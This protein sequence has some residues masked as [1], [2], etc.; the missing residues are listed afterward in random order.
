MRKEIEK[1]R[2]GEINYNKFGTKMKIIEYNG[3]MN[4]LVE[5]QDEYRY[6]VK[7]TY[8]QFKNREIKNVYDKEVQNVGYIGEGEYQAK[9][10]N[11]ITKEYICWRGMLK[12][13]YD[14]YELNKEP[15]Y[16]NCYVCE[17]WLCFQNFAKW[18]EENIY[19]I[20]NQ[21]VQLDKD[22]LIKGNKIYSPDTCIFVP[23]RINGLFTK[24][25]NNRGKDVIGVFWENDRNKFKATCSIYENKKTKQICKRFNTE[26]EAFN[27]YK[28]QKEKEIKRR[29]NEYK[30]LIPQKLYEALYNYKVEIDD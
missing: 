16:I 5:F 30:D 13:C 17:E 2:I 11:K 22:I 28:E 24:R 9:K 10:N 19:Q 23:Q 4:I 7:A 15:S 1:N 6:R 27:W 12:R 14:P 25:Q 21:N 18:Y 20:E 29:A 3:S 8:Q 26:I